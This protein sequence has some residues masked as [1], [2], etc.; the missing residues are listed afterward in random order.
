MG[1]S[2]V[3][4][5]IN[6]KGYKMQSGSRQVQLS[7]TGLSEGVIPLGNLP[8]TRALSHP[9]VSEGRFS[10]PQSSVFS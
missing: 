4:L 10:R 1:N 5:E 3:I 7:T 8:Q 9:R 2:V 6:G